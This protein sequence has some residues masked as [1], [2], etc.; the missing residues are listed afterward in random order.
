MSWWET[1]HLVTWWKRLGISAIKTGQ[2]APSWIWCTERLSFLGGA[3]SFYSVSCMS[4]VIFNPSLLNWSSLIL[5]VAH[6]SKY[7][8]FRAIYYII[9]HLSVSIYETSDYNPCLW[10]PAV[11]LPNWWCYLVPSLQGHQQELGHLL[12]RSQ[13]ISF[14]L[15]VTLQWNVTKTCRCGRRSELFGRFVMHLC[16]LPTKLHCWHVVIQKSI[17]V[18]RAEAVLSAAWMSQPEKELTCN[19]LPN[20]RNLLQNPTLNDLVWWKKLIRFAVCKCL[21]YNRNTWNWSS[22]K[23]D[24]LTEVQLGPIKSEPNVFVEGAKCQVS[25]T[26]FHETNERKSQNHHTSSCYGIF[27][28]FHQPASLSSWSMLGPS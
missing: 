10:Y 21:Q 25:H 7:T 18:L 9:Y 4:D 27:R 28:P 20:L 6:I 1:L 3:I 17:L 14:V 19:S 15:N 24:R 12:N 11:T 22:L 16:L 26:T 5:T 2:D 13:A 8:N 23:H